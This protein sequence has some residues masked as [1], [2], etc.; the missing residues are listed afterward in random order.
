M[1]FNP[2]KRDGLDDVTGEPLEKRDDDNPGTFKKRIDSFQK[3]TEPMISMFRQQTYPPAPDT[4]L[5]VDIAGETSDAIWP[6]LEG[7]IK[8]RFAHLALRT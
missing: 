3:Q 5:L 6:K 8:E 2:P 4:P 1:S 7:L